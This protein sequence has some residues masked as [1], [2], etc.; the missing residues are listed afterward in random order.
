[1]C[2]GIYFVSFSETILSFS[3]DRKL[4][5]SPDQES[6]VNKSED[7]NDVDCKEDLKFITLH[8]VRKL[9]YIFPFSI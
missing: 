5:V 6:Q 9:M 7:K 2:V 3:S 1:M 8:N 4:S